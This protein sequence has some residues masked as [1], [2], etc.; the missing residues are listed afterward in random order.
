MPQKQ[1]SAHCPFVLRRSRAR[2]SLLLLDNVGLGVAVI[3]G[4]EVTVGDGALVG[5]GSTVAV[6]VEVGVDVGIS[7][8][9]VEV[10]ELLAEGCLDATW[11]G[12]GVTHP[13]QFRFDKINPQATTYLHAAVFFM[14]PQ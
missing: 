3:V 8:V 10:I 2:L 14:V 12:V 11:I 13:L 9:D 1:G 6:A 5:V 7:G 4:D